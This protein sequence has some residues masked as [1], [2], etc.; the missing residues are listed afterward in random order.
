MGLIGAEKDFLD[1]TLNFQTNEHPI[2]C[3]LGGCNPASLARAAKVCEERGF[4]EINLN[5]GCPSKYSG[6]QVRG[7]SLMKNPERVRDCVK[8]VTD[9]VSIPVSVKCR[10]GV[11]DFDTP[12]WTAHFVRTVAEGG[13]RHFIVHARKAWLKGLSAQ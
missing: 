13:V 10:L 1:S 3:Q 2:V 7:A 6:L 12:E 4:D 8:C 11:D 9:A 5:C